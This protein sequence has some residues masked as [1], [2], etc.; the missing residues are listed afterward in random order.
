ML[1]KFN[2][3]FLHENYHFINL[4]DAIITLNEGSKNMKEN[5][6]ELMDCNRIVLEN[7][8]TK[9]CVGS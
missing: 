4:V 8:A 6:N 1:L 5:I 7:L 3:I 2:A 9:V